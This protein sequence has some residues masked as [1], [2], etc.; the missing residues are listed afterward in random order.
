MLLISIFASPL[1]LFERIEAKPSWVKPFFIAILLMFIALVL[2]YPANQQLT[3]RNLAHMDSEQIR[4]IQSTIRMS[5]YFSFFM[6]PVRQLIV[7]SLTAYFLY[8]ILMAFGSRLGYRK[9]LALVACASILRSLDVLGGAAMNLVC[10][11]SRIKELADVQTSFLG[12][13]TFIDLGHHPTVRVVAN[14]LS[15]LS[16]WYWGILI[17]GISSLTK[18]SKFRAAGSVIPL[19][20]CQVAL[21]VISQSLLSTAL[22]W[23]EWG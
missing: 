23:G 22:R 14:S 7:L 21:Q 17:A 13:G 11:T 4:N 20:V 18:I 16:L 12:A 3:S 6:L 2:L 1:S 5:N 15:P 9:M 19:F 8:V 10:G